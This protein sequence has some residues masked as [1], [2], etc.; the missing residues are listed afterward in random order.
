MK[1][2]FVML[3]L[4][5]SATALSAQST[6]VVLHLQSSD[7]LVYKSVVNQVGNIKKAIPD[8]TIELVCHG[9][10]ID[11]LKKGSV[12]VEKIQRLKLSQVT[13][14]GCEFTMKQ[15]NI[16]KGD[17]VAYAITV[18]YGLVEIIHKQ[19]EGWAYVKLGF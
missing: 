7:T 5:A 19:K 3:A 13:F 12:Y 1:R 18:P 4:I 9:P 17:L 8:A 11:F 16:N 10:G 6:Q 2:I 15:K 14:A